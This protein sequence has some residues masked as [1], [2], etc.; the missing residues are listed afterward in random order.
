MHKGPKLAPLFRFCGLR[1]GF[2]WKTP[3]IFL[4]LFPFFVQLNINEIY[5]EHKNKMKGPTLKH[6]IILSSGIP[7][8]PQSCTCRITSLTLWYWSWN[9]SCGSSSGR[10]R[11]HSRRDTETDPAWGT[12]APVPQSMTSKAII[13]PTTPIPL[14]KELL[15]LHLTRIRSRVF[16]APGLRCDD[17]FEETKVTDGTHNPFGTFT[18]FSFYASAHSHKNSSV[19]WNWVRNRPFPE[20]DRWVP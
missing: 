10:A 14:K 17:E 18:I 5:N 15:N 20:P 6:P 19:A 2:Y 3:I 1:E 13:E 12:Y 7:A 16:E 9:W 8:P 11:I 4:I